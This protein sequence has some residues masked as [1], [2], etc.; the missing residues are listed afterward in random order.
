MNIITRIEKYKK[1]AEVEK[2]FS[3][4][5]LLIC[6]IRILSQKLS[7]LRYLE[8]N[9]C[10]Y[11][12]EDHFGEHIGAVIKQ[13]V[14]YLA[15]G[16]EAVPEFA[17]GVPDNNSAEEVEKKSDKYSQDRSAQPACCTLASENA[18]NAQRG[19]CKYV[20]KK[21]AGDKHYGSESPAEKSV[22]YALE[23]LKEGEHKRCSEACL[24]AS[25]NAVDRNGE[26]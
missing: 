9:E 4:Q 2:T 24:Y 20:V 12:R 19:V 10:A 15:V 13:A 3:S 11:S 14:K 18:C 1:T 21:Y 16:G 17:V 6:S 25:F 26:H 8:K 7:C 5:S 23:E 22:R